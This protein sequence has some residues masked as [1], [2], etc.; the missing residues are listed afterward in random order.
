MF[1]LSL[2]K[3]TEVSEEDWW[4]ISD[5]TRTKPMNYRLTFNLD[6][7][8]VL[9]LYAGNNVAEIPFFCVKES[10]LFNIQSFLWHFIYSV[11]LS[12][13]CCA[14]KDAL[15]IDKKNNKTFLFVETGKRYLITFL[16]KL[17]FP[18]NKWKISFVFV[19]LLFFILVLYD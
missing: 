11:Y 1:P 18:I 16:S 6:N 5:A 14:G 10:H 13:K 3:S 2:T 9:G 4:P 12:L 15:S 7:F 8:Y 17:T 19:K